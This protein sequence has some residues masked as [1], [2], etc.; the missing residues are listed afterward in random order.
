MSSSSAPDVTVHLA[1]VP[2]PTDVFYFSGPVNIQYQLSVTNPTNE[3]MTLTRLDLETLG[4]GAYSLRTAA[5]PMNLKV[6]PNSTAKNLISVWGRARGG[7]L[8]ASEPVTIR[9]TAYFQDQA[10]R[11]SFVRIFSENIFPG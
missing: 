1:Q 6:P 5:T 9:G 10:T 7:Y 8:S 11:K 3:P 4:P 2:M